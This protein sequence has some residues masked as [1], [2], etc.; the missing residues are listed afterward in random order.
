VNILLLTSEFAPAN[1]GIGTYAR[2]IASAATDL[3]AKVTVIAPDYALDNIAGDGSFRF[4]V[5]RFPGGLHSMRDLPAKIRLV[6]GLLARGR[7]GTERYD[8]VHA[9]DWPFFIPVA[10][11]RRLT[12][13]RLLMTVHGTEINETQTLLKRLAIRSAGVFGPR[14]EITA[15]SRYTRE[16]FRERFAVDARRI[17]AVR[18][19]VSDLPSATAA[20]PRGQRLA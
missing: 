16:L 6:R 5:Q 7:L 19:G 3:G 4:E 8:V 14:T 12:Q 13:A 9:A 11:S 2:E 17:K 1:G 18:L 20:P 15:N 10:L